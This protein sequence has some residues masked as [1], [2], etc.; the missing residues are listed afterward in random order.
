MNPYELTEERKAR[1]RV[2][3]KRMRDLLELSPKE[4]AECAGDWFTVMGPA[5]TDFR[6]YWAGMWY[7]AAL[8]DL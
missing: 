7:A 8:G 1:I 2:K 4:C 5:P 3:V 6:A